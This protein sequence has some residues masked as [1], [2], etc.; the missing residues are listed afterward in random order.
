MHTNDLT[1]EVTHLI[2]GDYNTPKY[3]HV[4][5]ERPDIK[6][7]CVG[8]VNA[9]L[10]LW[11][12]DL[13]LDKEALE[14]A[15]RLRTFEVHGGLPAG[16][17]GQADTNNAGASRQPPAPPE[18]GRLLCSVTGLEEDERHAAIDAI[19]RN[20]GVYSGDLTRAVTHLIVKKPEGKKYAAA[21]HWNIRTVSIEWLRDCV[22]RRMILDE[23]KYDPRLPP[24]ER[25]KGGVLVRTAAERAAVLG[26]RLRDAAASAAAERQGQ[27]KLRKTASMKLSV[28]R[29][30]LWGHILGKPAAEPGGS[31]REGAGE[32]EGDRRAAN[33]TTAQAAHAD[34]ATMR[35]ATTAADTG[36]VLGT[37]VFCIHGF[38]PARAE[39]LANA[40]ATMGGSVA[41][42][43]DQMATVAAAH[44]QLRQHIIVPQ[45]E[46]PGA[47]PSVAADVL[48]VT[49]FFIEKCLHK[50][51]YALSLEADGPP[52]PGVIGRPFPVFPIPGFDAL[53]ICTSGFTGVDLNQVDKS[54]RQLGAKYEERFTAQCSVLVVAALDTVRRQ[55]LEL[56]LS[57]KVPVV[58]ASWL[59]ACI[60]SGTLVAIDRYLFPELMQEAPA[61][62]GGQR[63]NSGHSAAAGPQPVSKEPPSSEQLEP[64]MPLTVPTLVVASANSLLRRSAK[65]KQDTAAITGKAE[66]K[67]GATCK[68]AADD[69][70]MDP[71]APFETAPTHQLDDENHFSVPEPR[72][73]VSRPRSPS[74]DEPP[75]APPQPQP[76][77]QS[78]KALDR[79]V[80]EIADSAAG[81]ESD[82]PIESQGPAADDRRGTGASAAVGPV[83]PPG[84]QTR[85]PAP[86][87]GA[88]TLKRGATTAAPPRTMPRP[89]RPALGRVVSDGPAAAGASRQHNHHSH[90]VHHPPVPLGISIDDLMKDGAAGSATAAASRRTSAG[91]AGQ[92]PG[93]AAAFGRSHSSVAFMAVADNGG[94]DAPLTSAG[95]AAAT[96][97]DAA[98]ANPPPTQEVQ[99]QYLDPQAERAREQLMRKIMGGDSGGDSG[100]DSGTGRNVFRESRRGRSDGAGVATTDMGGAAA[101]DALRPV[102]RRSSRLR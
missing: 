36:G 32:G 64:T 74:P 38:T 51:Q 66:P 73:D 99:V 87:A 11:T 55:K 50:K 1:H 70:D 42:S 84:K 69:A 24:E 61:V 67:E 10:D 30:D 63:D 101:D 43:V 23:T 19:V 47:H 39:V 52:G 31:S 95:A 37:S 94:R 29:D 35:P 25:G 44:P 80:S 40:V 8:W 7:M 34:A 20:G 59:W 41:S 86:A 91:A 77:Q 5:Y 60:A 49:E 75:P 21:L 3:R 16:A 2:V 4:A 48:P 76:R 81:D 33:S 79:V 56:A 6:P 98:A 92:A 13:P 88:R 71:T 26:K 102:V 14:E 58:D 12:Q 54:V 27:R 90:H 100:S 82:D 65:A 17:D 62:L 85:R 22:E 83:S 93:H 28:Q 97:P 72:L 68:T 18:R 89:P 15:W 78:R 57:W 46:P 9:V 53:S 96:M 45:V